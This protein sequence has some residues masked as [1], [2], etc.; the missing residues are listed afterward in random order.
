MK[1]LFSSAGIAGK[2]DKALGALSGRVEDAA[3]SFTERAQVCATN[4]LTPKTVYQVVLKRHFPHKIVNLFFIFVIEDTTASFA[5]HA[6]VCATV[7][8]LVKR[9]GPFGL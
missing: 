9:K 8:H 4:L 7:A 6:Q 3:S 2:C 1:I 5:E